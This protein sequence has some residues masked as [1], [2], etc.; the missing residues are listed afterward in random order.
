MSK[1][2]EQFPFFIVYAD[3]TGY[4]SLLIDKYGEE[5]AFIDVIDRNDF[6]DQCNNPHKYKKNAAEL[7][8]ELR[9]CLVDHGFEAEVSAG[10]KAFSE[11]YKHRGKTWTHLSLEERWSK[12]KLVL[13]LEDPQE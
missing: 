6:M 7:L 1:K 10:D 11:R 12:E 8:L 13:K 9:Q 2:V 5:A 4:C 3:I